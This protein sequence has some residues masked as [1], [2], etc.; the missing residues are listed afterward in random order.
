MNHLMSS[1]AKGV[2][3]GAA[4]GT[5]AYMVKAKKQKGRMMKKSA[6]KAMKT[7]GNVMENVAYMM[8]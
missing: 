5:A 3:V 6:T 4:V 7:I 2:A 8:K 1:V